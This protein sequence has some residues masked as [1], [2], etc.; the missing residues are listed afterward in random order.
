MKK[1]NDRPYLFE[2]PKKK[3]KRK[4]IKKKKKKRTTYED[5]LKKREQW[6]YINVFSCVSKHVL[7]NKHLL[8]PVIFDVRTFKSGT[9]AA[10]ICATT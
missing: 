1:K 2:K 4:K 3:K 6:K 5:F 9:R 10:G 7:K 8:H